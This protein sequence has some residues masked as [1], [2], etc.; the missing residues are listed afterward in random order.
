MMTPMDGECEPQVDPLVQ[1]EGAATVLYA[2]QTNGP[3]DRDALA[4]LDRLAWARVQGLPNQEFGAL[5]RD[6]GD[7]CPRR[8]T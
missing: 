4:R 7:T 1:A 3:G 2:E 6:Q 5:V 8:P